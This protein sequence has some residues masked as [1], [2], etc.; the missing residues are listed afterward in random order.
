MKENIIRRVVA[1]FLL[2]LVVLAYVAVS[3]VRNIQQSIKSED[4]VNHTHAVIMDANGRWA[5]RPK[6]ILTVML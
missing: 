3:A 1:L 6:I 2:M 4:W 5:K